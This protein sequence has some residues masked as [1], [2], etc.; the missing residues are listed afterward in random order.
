MT[1]AQK[2]RQSRDRLGMTQKEFAEMLGVSKS[3]VEKWEAKGRQPLP[4]MQEGIFAR[5]AKHESAR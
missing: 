4:V 2:L 1:F 3:S 5:I